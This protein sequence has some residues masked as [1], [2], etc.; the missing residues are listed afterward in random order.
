MNYEYYIKWNDH[1]NGIQIASGNFFTMIEIAKMLEKKKTYYQIGSDRWYSQAECNF[2]K[3]IFKYWI[4]PE[5]G[6]LW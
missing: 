2:S 5:E 4:N 6:H 3:N 1:R